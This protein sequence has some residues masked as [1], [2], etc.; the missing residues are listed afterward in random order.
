V[1]AAIAPYRVLFPLGA[2]FAVGGA[3]PWLLH[4]TGAPGYPA[5]LHRSLMIQGFELSFVLGFLLTSIPAFTH[6]APCRPW[7][8]AAAVAGQLL[9]GAFALAGLEAAAH[10]A[11]VATLLLLAIAAARRVAR[12]AILPPEELLFVGI[13]LGLGVAG[14]VTQLGSALDWWQEPS[15][16]LGVRLVSLGMMLSLVLGVGSMLVPVFAGVRD[17]LVLPGIA[18][19]HERRHRRGLYVT[20]ASMLALSFAAD[21]FG[22][23]PLG[24]WVRVLVASV[25]GLLGWKLHRRPGRAALLPWALWAS[26]WT[27]LLGLAL[28]AAFPLR[29]IGFHHLVF[30]GG[31]GTLTLAIATRVITGHGRHPVTDEARMVTPL[32]ASLIALALLL[33]VGAEFAPRAAPWLGGSAALWIAAWL[34]WCAGALPRIARL[35]GTSAGLSRR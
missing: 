26:G 1:S 15:P 33:R 23:E 24:P 28:A 12:A 31:Y 8:L 6:G 29:A 4:A 3:A 10:A 5:V 18:G 30:L 22:V 27:M 14:G 9:F 13:G 34:L 32:V 17:P 11:F 25:L 35:A 19:P 21:A 20:L 2:A 16:R 7:E